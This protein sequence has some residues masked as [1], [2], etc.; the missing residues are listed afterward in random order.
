MIH[1]FRI[2][3]DEPELHLATGDMLLVELQAHEPVVRYSSL[4]LNFL[5][6]LPLLVAQGIATTTLSDDALEALASGTEPLATVACLA[7]RGEPDRRQDDRRQT[8][9]RLVSGGQD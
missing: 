7:P 6:I 4:P 2:I 9:L 8:H 5:A 3:H 1:T